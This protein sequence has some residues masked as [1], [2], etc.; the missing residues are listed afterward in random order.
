VRRYLG[1]NPF[2]FLT[3]GRKIAANAQ[4]RAHTA[5]FCPER[6]QDDVIMLSFPRGA[7][8]RAH[9]ARAFGCARR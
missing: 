1:R 4:A 9:V 8:A 6:S 2:A 5:A 3:K 7:R